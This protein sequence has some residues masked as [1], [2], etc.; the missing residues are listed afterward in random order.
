[1]ISV[2]SLSPSSGEV[3]RKEA[4]NKL[5][6]QCA[7]ERLDHTRFLLRLAELELI[8]RERRMG[9]CQLA[10]IMI[11]E[12]MNAAPC[13]FPA[14]PYKGTVSPPRSS[15]TAFAVISIRPE[16]PRC[17]AHPIGV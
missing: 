7:A 13:V 16:L 15:A 12:A 1:L 17:G 6:R 3:D 14:S 9:N 4:T 5:A 2:S 10:A 11:D 8:E